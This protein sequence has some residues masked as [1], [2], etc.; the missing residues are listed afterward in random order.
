MRRT[1]DLYLKILIPVIFVA[2]VVYL[3]FS[4]WNG[5]RNPYSFQVVY[6]DTM[7]DSVASSGWVV[8]AETPLYN[9]G[10]LVQ[11][12]RTQGEKVG[13][14]QE[15]AVIYQDEQY[16]AHQEELEQVKIDLTALQYATYEG[17]PTGSPLEEQ[18]LSSLVALRTQ[19]STGQFG[20]VDEQAAQYRKLI[21]RREYL[22][23][24]NAAAEMTQAAANLYY[25]MNELQGLQYGRDTVIAAQSGTFSSQLDGYETYIYPDMIGAVTPLEVQAFDD[26][27]PASDSSCFGKLIT[28][29]TWYYAALVDADDADGF[30]AGDDVKVSFDAISDTMDMEVESVS[31]SQ[32]GKAVVLFRS[33]EK[34]GEVLS[35]RHESA[36]L[37]FHFYD[38]LRV[39]KDALRITEDG[40]T[41]VYVVSGYT[42]SFRPVKILAEDE[43]SYLVK[44][45]PA[46]AESTRIL[47]EGD[48]IILASAELYDGKVVR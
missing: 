13:K 35:L 4:A 5:V 34:I 10:G 27:E 14:G 2:I 15:I 20:D 32:E 41:G 40:Q 38:G 6:A 29:F 17:S 8:R 23:S 43:T 46:D 33:S 36:R 7:E 21:L 44:A 18:M 31:E 37:V 26:I 30:T 1:D 48:E 12:L 9:R 45:N 28:S 42:A 19:A 47:R 24:G 22:V 11:L 39:P 16:A 3:I 25:R